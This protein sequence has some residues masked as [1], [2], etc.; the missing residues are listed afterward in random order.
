MSEQVVE[1]RAD[2]GE[3]FGGSRSRGTNP[4]LLH[5]L[6]VKRVERELVE[7]CANWRA[8]LA[9][10]VPLARQALRA[11]MPERQ[12]ILLIPERDGYRLRGVTRLGALFGEAGNVRTSKMASPRGDT[13]HESFGK[14][15]WEWRVAA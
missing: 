15:D 7:R 12:P 8:L 2:V 14:L 9:G 4:P 13:L 3:G 11:L 6:D 1:N 5:A 10:D